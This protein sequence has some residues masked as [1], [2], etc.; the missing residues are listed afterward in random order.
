MSKFLYRYRSIQAVIGE[1]Q[2]L[3]NLERSKLQKW[4]YLSFKEY[5]YFQLP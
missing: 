1:W 5:V 2:E 3:E 4:T